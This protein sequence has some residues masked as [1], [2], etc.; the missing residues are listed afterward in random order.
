MFLAERKY[1]NK[2]SHIMR[3]QQSLEYDIKTAK[4]PLHT[5]QSQE[6]SIDL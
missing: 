4:S 6:W 2:P 5:I 3:K 1:E